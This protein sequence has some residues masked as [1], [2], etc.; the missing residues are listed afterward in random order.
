MIP[1]LGVFVACPMSGSGLCRGVRVSVFMLRHYSV[2]P[3]F[4]ADHRPGDPGS[5]LFL[6]RLRAPASGAIQAL[7]AWN[8]GVCYLLILGINPVGA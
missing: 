4:P 1:L 8:S 5:A 7:F 2:V 3:W 6:G